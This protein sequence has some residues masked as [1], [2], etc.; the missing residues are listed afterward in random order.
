[1]TK[2]SNRNRTG[3]PRTAQGISRASGNAMTHGAYSGVGLW[4]GE[5][6]A[7]FDQVLADFLEDH[8]PVGRT[9][10]VLVRRL[11]D[12]YWKILRLQRIESTQYELAMN[13]PITVAE[14]ARFGVELSDDM[15]WVLNNLQRFDQELI[16]GFREEIEFCERLLGGKASNEDFQIL[17]AEYPE[18]YQHLVAMAREIRVQDYSDDTLMSFHVLDRMGRSVHATELWAHGVVVGYSELIEAYER[19]DEYFEVFQKIRVQRRIDLMAHSSLSRVSEDLN[20][21]F[22]KG[23]AELRKQQAWRFEHRVIDVTPTVQGSQQH[24]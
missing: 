23:L 13:A 18:I 24:V 20:R 16:D 14:M 22:A 9:E 11:A 19:R 5:I 17:K 8:Q 2:P 21:A 7:E 15:G 10:E 4:S 3:G 12:V 6:Q 1:M